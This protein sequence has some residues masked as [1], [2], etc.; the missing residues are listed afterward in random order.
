MI[1]PLFLIPASLIEAHAVFPAEPDSRLNFDHIT[2]PYTATIRK[3]TDALHV[4]LSIFVSLICIYRLPDVFSVRPPF[5]CRPWPALQKPTLPLHPV[6]T[7]SAKKPATNAPDYAAS[8]V[9]DVTSPN[10]DV[11]SG[12]GS[13]ATKIQHERA[14]QSSTIAAERK[15][16]PRRFS[17]CLHLPVLHVELGSAIADQPGIL[18]LHMPVRPKVPAFVIRVLPKAVLTHRQLT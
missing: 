13:P 3:T 14:D 2:Q 17:L 7:H 15:R 9:V 12:H 16:P 8:R 1:V 18:C 5:S 11:R 10:L 6:N 4:Y